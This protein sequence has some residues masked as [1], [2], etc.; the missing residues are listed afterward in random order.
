MNIDNINELVDIAKAGDM[1][2]KNELIE[3]NKGFIRRVSSYIS[4]RNLDWSNDDELSIA[5]IAF[6]EAIDSFKPD[7]GMHFLSYCRML[8]NSRLIDY[9]RKNGNSAVP[10]CAIEEE[11]LNFMEDREAIDRYLISSA[12]EERSMEIRLY[13]E[14]LKKYSLSMSDLVHNCPKHKDTRKQLFET[15]I[16]CSRDINIVRSLKK[17]RLLPIKDIIELTGLKR[18]FIEQWRKYLIALII[19][20]SSDEYLYIKEYICFN[21]RKV[22]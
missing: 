7:K 19:A 3:A 8:I 13:N 22:V 16:L 4:K 14:E 21:E 6:N 5:L 11:E 20:A 17:T 10:L 2:V 1:E 18:K 12:A 9:F 15:A